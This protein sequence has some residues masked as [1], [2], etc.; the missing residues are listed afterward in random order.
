MRPRSESILRKARLWESVWPCLAHL[1]RHLPTCRQGAPRARLN[2]AF[3][4]GG[5][6]NL[7]A[8]LAFRPDLLPGYATF[9][10]M[11]A[12]LAVMAVW[13]VRRKTLFR[14]GVSLRSDGR[15]SYQH[16]TA[17]GGDKGPD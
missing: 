3:E 16:R 13:V 8:N 11:A 2:A 5:S 15:L 4:R 6:G 10:F 9:L 1:P 7:K 14:Q 17:P 12:S